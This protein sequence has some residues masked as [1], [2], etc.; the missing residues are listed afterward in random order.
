[1]IFLNNCGNTSAKNTPASIA[2]ENQ[3]RK[4][5]SPA[6]SNNN[7]VTRTNMIG[8]RKR[9]KALFCKGCPQL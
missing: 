7:D 6:R 5:C 2:I 3:M 9:G 1:M 8:K 4:K